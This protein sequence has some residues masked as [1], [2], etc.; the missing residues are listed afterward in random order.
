MG[1]GVPSYLEKHAPIQKVSGGQATFGRVVTL[2]PSLVPASITL[3]FTFT[4]HPACIY[5]TPPNV[6]YHLPH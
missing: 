2:D 3:F 1:T 6:G 5:L 4:P